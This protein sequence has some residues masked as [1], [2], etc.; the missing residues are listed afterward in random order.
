VEGSEGKVRGLERMNRVRGVGERVKGFGG[1]VRCHRLCNQQMYM[2][3]IWQTSIHL[4]ADILILRRPV[5]IPR[6][7]VSPKDYQRGQK[8]GSK[9]RT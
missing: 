3:K 8:E 9:R 7:K 5:R 6:G 4:Y 2:C 1:R